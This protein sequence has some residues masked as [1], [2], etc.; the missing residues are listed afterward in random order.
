MRSGHYVAYFKHKRAWYLADDACVTKLERA[1]V[2]FPYVVFLARCGRLVGQHA[3]ASQKRSAWVTKARRDAPP[4]PQR[5]VGLTAG[6]S[7]KSFGQTSAA[8]SSSQ[9][10]PLLE[11][12]S[13][14][15]R[16]SRDQRGRRQN[17]GPRDDERVDRAWGNRGGS[18]NRD[19]SGEDDHSCRDDPY[20]RYVD[21]YGLRRTNADVNLP[22]LHKLI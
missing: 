21:T 6:S 12:G 19:Y 3:K 17:V 7:A 15:D 9:L 5:S 1:P 16:T 8:A 10:A 22:T 11:K 4:L 2:E 18:D 14:R 20:K 13:A